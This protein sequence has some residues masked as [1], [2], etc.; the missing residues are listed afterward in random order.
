MPLPVRL[1]A[2][3]VGVA[4]LWCASLSAM[5]ALVAATQSYHAW[6]AITER[7][8]EQCAGAPYV[9]NERP[10]SHPVPGFCEPVRPWEL[11]KDVVD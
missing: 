1:L 8:N 4:L 6:W 10:F 7:W 2:R 11:W 9:A 3:A 5:S